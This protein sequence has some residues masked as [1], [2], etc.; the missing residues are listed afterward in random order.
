VKT[1]RGLIFALLSGSALHAAASTFTVS[2]TNNAG[3][4]SLAQAVTDANQNPGPDTIA[5]G[6]P[7]SP[8]FSI[9]LQTQLPYIIGPVTIDGTTQPG[10]AGKPVIEINGAGAGSSADGLFFLTG[11]AGSTV[12][13]LVINRFAQDG[14]DLQTASNTVQNCFIGTDLTGTQAL[15]NGADGI[16]IFEAG[17]NLIGG[18]AN[19]LGNVISGNGGAGI[20][21]A[22]GPANVIQGNVIGADLTGTQPLGNGD[23]GIQLPLN[24]GGLSGNS[25]GN[26]VG[27]VTPGAGNTIAFN[28]RVGV[29]IAQGHQVSV[30]GNSIFG[31][32]GIGIDLGGGY[33]YPDGP[34]ANHTGSAGYGPNGFQNYP[35]ITSVTGSGASTTIQGTLNSAAN[36][37]FR[38][39]F[40]S[41]PSPA[42]RFTFSEGR[43][44]LGATNLTTD[45]SGNASFT[46][47]FPVAAQTVTATATDSAGDT[48]EFST[49]AVP[50]PSPI[51]QP[52]DLFAGVGYGLIQWRRSDGTPV[53]LLDTGQPAQYSP[54]GL[55]FDPAGN[56]FAG[57]QSGNSV[58]KFDPTGT[59][60]GASGP[61]GDV[62]SGVECDALGDVLAGT[63][64]SGL[65][66]LDPS[67][68]LVDVFPFA[69]STFVFDLAADQRTLF[70]SSFTVGSLSQS[71]LR[72]DIANDAPLPA[73]VTNLSGPR[74]SDLRLLPGGG[75]LMANGNAV[76]QLDV[77]G[78]PTRTLTSNLLGGRTVRL[79]ADGKSVWIVGADPYLYK[80][81]LAT[82]TLLARRYI[83]YTL[84]PPVYPPTQLGPPTALAVRGEP[85]AATSSVALA[86]ASNPNPAATGQNLTY[87]LTAVNNTAATVTGVKV[88]D[89]LPPSASYVSATTG[90]G[91][92]SQSA[93]GVTFNVGSL[94]PGASVTMTLTVATTVAGSLNNTAF[95]TGDGLDPASSNYLALAT[96]LVAN[97]PLTPFTV[98][99]TNNS[100]PGS[101]RAAINNANVYSNTAPIVFNLPGPGVH[102][103][104]LTGLLAITNTVILDGY[105]QPGASPNTLEQGDNA[106]VLVEI[107]GNQL[108]LGFGSYGSV[109]RGLSL[110][111]LNL[112][113]NSI[114]VQGNFIGVDPTGTAA[115]TNA[116]GGSAFYLN[117]S[118]GH[119]LG[120]P[121]PA[122]RNLISGLSGYGLPGPP[123]L[124]PSPTL[125]Q[126]NYIGTDHTGAAALGNGGGDGIDIVEPLQVI[127]GT[128][129]GDGNVIAFNRG[130][131]VDLSDRSA[132]VMLEGNSIFANGG[133]G[134]LGESPALT[135]TE[136]TPG[137]GTVQG[138][139][140]GSAQAGYRIELFANN[141]CDPSGYGQGQTF[142]GA[143]LASTD[144]SGAGAFS[145]SVSPP[146]VSGAIITATVTPSDP[147]GTTSAFSRCVAVAPPLDL[148]LN[149]VG[150]TAPA[151]ARSN[152]T[153]LVTITN[154]SAATA[155]GVFLEVQ[156]P[157]H[158]E[159][160][161]GSAGCSNYASSVT[162]L[163]PSLAGGATTTASITV[164]PQYIG[165]MT[166]S[167]LVVA[168]Q[169]VSLLARNQESLT[170]TA[171]N[172]S[173]RTLLV[174]N[175]ASYGPGSL[176]Q[177]ISDA[178][179]G[180][181]GD[182]IAFN[183]PGA[184]VQTNQ[185]S[186]LP[187]L[188]VPVTIDGYTQPGAS[189]NALA[190]GD[191]AVLLIDLG[192]AS[193]DL[194]GGFSTARG[195]ALNGILLE[196]PSGAL[197]SNVVE[198]CFIG[199]DASGRVSRMTQNSGIQ[200]AGSDDDR[201]GGLTPAARNLISGTGTGTPNLTAAIQTDSARTVVQG[202]LIGTDATG[203]APLGNAGAGIYF[204]GTPQ[205]GGLV[206]GTE[207]GAANVIAFNGGPGVVVAAPGYGQS[208]LGNSIYGN[209]GIGIA[210]GG[211]GSVSDPP[212]TNHLSGF[213]NAPV[214]TNLTNAGGSTTIRG[215]LNGVSNTTYR[216]EFFSSPAPTNVFFFSEGRTFLGFADVTTGAD[217]GAVFNPTFPGA[218]DLVAATA[219]DPAGNT[220]AFFMYPQ[221]PSPGCFQP[222]DL[223]VGFTT[224]DVQWRRA[225]GQPV[226]I[227]FSQRFD[228]LGGMA[229]DAGGRLLVTDGS[230]GQLDR[231]DSCGQP[232]G[233]L[234]PG[235]NTRPTD[236]VFDFAGNL[237]V[238][239]DDV[240][241]NVWKYDARGNLVAQ[242]T[243]AS[244]GIGAYFIDLA[245]DQHT[246]CYTSFGAA[247][248]RFDLEAQQQL[249]D[250][251]TNLVYAGGL[252]L[253]PDG[254]LVVAAYG[255]LQRLDA[256]ANV[257]WN[258]SVPGVN[259][260]YSVKL[261]PDGRTF[262]SVA[263]PNQVYH[264]DLGSGAV[265]GHFQADVA[266]S[267]LGL[268]LRGEPTAATSGSAAPSL[269]I[270]RYGPQIVLSWPASA[271]GFV[272]RA[273]A[274]LGTSANWQSNST[275]PA[276][277]GGRYLVTNALPTATEFFRLQKP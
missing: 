39:E 175:T 87:T 163:V 185:S 140:Q 231:L 110:E 114:A 266:S 47:T 164:Q 161:S 76:T 78:N 8:P 221:P 262:W 246:L 77:T 208:V 205:T 162:C 170:I 276:V 119:Q 40:F 79:D 116:S 85:A 94:A 193:L 83:E 90:Q 88:S 80:V 219:T 124:N 16:A 143:T 203:A 22:N 26:A 131:G 183:I 112:G 52:G 218:S 132:G 91:T 145:A 23:D 238:G 58:V 142:I 245:A 217:G 138:L 104:P 180:V 139:F 32:A 113:D 275:P 4:G 86:T 229:W 207:S 197:G 14:I 126:G 127:G 198:G 75:F 69:T 6:L 97:G 41:N 173:P 242:Y 53:R 36:A 123:R 121:D 214:I 101:L 277:A 204:S 2:N 258:S 99:T 133:P 237:Y 3:P 111:A 248:K 9:P 89:T 268:A 115:L 224:G 38:L 194:A 222:G 63:Y 273:S 158:L 192:Q 105:T 167:F 107:T 96:T 67:A 155:T 176:Y 45:A 54:S 202:N 10:Y 102:Q 216:L 29:W 159:F 46:V 157:D 171:F 169:P 213:L 196:N 84:P 64:Q 49:A 235:T 27:G 189:P 73:L 225:D 199:T 147:N 37:T 106:I 154:N 165:P 70:Y 184:G 68:N 223:F 108:L 149:V 146:L 174:T 128:N 109:V 220:S 28:G 12:R 182:T 56:L 98:L 210:L 233:A 135:V 137:G 215:L 130:A 186:F 190:S 236:V 5:F 228:V 20:Q 55:A 51:P 125:I 7:G 18:A 17:Y 209:G 241:N 31:N 249:P 160:I 72:Y 21:V 270:A 150:P 254:G 144:A 200:I 195:L 263:S 181:G 82:G 260:W 251:V 156:L 25:D 93:G 239:F 166:T 129:R 117:A 134:I 13:G 272:L 206:G 153:F 179:D 34:T 256:E 1:F 230:A 252:R 118:F 240:T 177:A 212:Y 271:T 234:V 33:Q 152:F 187:A 211:I 74:L 50:P 136:A 60:L 100:G 265:L 227:V 172:A 122:E 43:V 188:Q 81:D 61:L 120:G 247:V 226:G 201:I 267:A 11:S 261:D 151:P 253:L 232:A 48:S 148:N 191:N 250:L 30:L 243:V 255:G 15:G 264:F 269:A 257:V 178:N 19:G 24:D 274:K 92:F 42:Y 95:L 244:E 259:V 66:K 62:V 71:I 103:I 57:T 59:P 168:D 141:A 65:A 44:F 35:V